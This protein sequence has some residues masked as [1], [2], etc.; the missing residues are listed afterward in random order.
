M[1]N[2]TLK[3][4]IYQNDIWQNHIFPLLQYFKTILLNEFM[5]SG[6]MLNANLEKIIRLNVVAPYILRII[7]GFLVPLGANILVQSYSLDWLRII[8]A[9]KR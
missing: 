6:I 3:N 9:L 4:D 1:L 5:F 8:L 2:D 7:P